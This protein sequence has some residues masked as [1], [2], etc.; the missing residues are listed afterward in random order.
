MFKSS[1]VWVAVNAAMSVMRGD[2][3]RVCR[4]PLRL[5][6]QEETGVECRWCG[7]ELFNSQD[8]EF[9]ELIVL[10]DDHIRICVG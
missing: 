8:F 10:V 7:V 1:K 9:V 2:A 5:I 4:W 3:D 6:G